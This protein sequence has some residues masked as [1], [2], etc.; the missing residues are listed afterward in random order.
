MSK[1]TCSA[2][3]Q[4]GHNVRSCPRGHS[5]ALPMLRIIAPGVLAAATKAAESGALVQKL[6]TPELRAAIDA[7]MKAIQAQNEASMALDKLARELPDGG[8][9]L[10]AKMREEGFMGL[11]DYLGLEP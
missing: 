3:G 7:H 6:T 4:Q 9:A 5:D 2:C 11:Y 10:F 1:Y 8:E